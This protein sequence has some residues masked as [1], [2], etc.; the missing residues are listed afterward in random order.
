M[1]YIIGLLQF[2]LKDGEE[3]PEKFRFFPVV[4]DFHLIWVI[5]IVK[6]S[7]SC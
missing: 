7:D 1:P 3:F 6:D 2:A 4:D 5:Q